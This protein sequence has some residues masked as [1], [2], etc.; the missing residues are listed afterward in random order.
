MRSRRLILFHLVLVAV[1]LCSAQTSHVAD[2]L[3]KIAPIL[4]EK[5]AVPLRFPSS[6][7]VLD[8][9]T[10][11]YAITRSVDQTAYWVVLGAT[12]DCY[13]QHQCSYGFF[14]GTTRP[15]RDFVG[16]KRGS[17]VE[18]RNGV[19]GSFYD[20]VCGAYCDESLIVWN[21]GRYNYIIGLKAEKK[22]T[23]V[24]VANSAIESARRM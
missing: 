13:G 19:N 7:P 12:P 8:N 18:L 11:L 9:E 6:I 24:Q 2:A 14:V 4:R 1:S 23:M 16:D 20:T 5:T 15:V 3:A 17:A 22:S 21:E 10:A